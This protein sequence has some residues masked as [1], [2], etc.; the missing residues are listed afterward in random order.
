MLILKI[1]MFAI[2]QTKL[3][4]YLGIFLMHE[5]S[6]GELLEIHLLESQLLDTYFQN[7]NC[8]TEKYW[9]LKSGLTWFEQLNKKWKLLD[10]V[11]Q[12]THNF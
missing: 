2:K 5:M 4:Q 10:S 11:E 6:Q 12:M 9:L 1:K 8:S 7:V 3:I